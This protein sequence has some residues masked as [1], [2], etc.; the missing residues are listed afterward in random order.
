M[1]IQIKRVQRWRKRRVK[2]ILLM[3]GIILVVLSLQPM[4]HL[5]KLRAA[6]DRFDMP[7]VAQEVKWMTER[8]P[9]LVKI[10]LVRDSALW[11][12]LNQGQALSDQAILTPA[13]DKHR[14]WLLQRKLQE[15]KITEA[16]QVLAAIQS[17]STQRLGQ[18]LVELAQGKTD[19]S[20]QTLQALP[21]LQLSQEEKVLKELAVSRCLLGKGDEAGA[22]TAWEK[23]RQLVPDHPAVR[24]EAFD[25]AL[26]RADWETAERLLPQLEQEQ[27]DQCDLDFQAKKALLFL[28]R[29]ETSQWDEVLKSLDQTAEGKACQ[30]YLLGVQSYQAGD[31]Q[32]AQKQFNV[33]LKGPLSLAL[34]QDATQSL[35]QVN[36]RLSAETH[37][38]KYGS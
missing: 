6:Q 13:D 38:G 33:S 15:G 24:E 21:E 22:Q 1:A 30:A 25:L 29:G 32:A 37:L 7:Q 4:R 34:R 26:I 2:G 5:L 35:Q 17:S 14:F 31:W 8:T 36:E 19:A 23:A 10:P 9:W 28:A 18:A 3:S 16:E 20:L 12:S 27:K 11:V